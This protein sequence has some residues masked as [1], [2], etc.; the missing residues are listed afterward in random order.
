[1]SKQLFINPQAIGRLFELRKGSS[2]I[3]PGAFVVGTA[4]ASFMRPGRD[5]F[6]SKKAIGKRAGIHPRNVSRYLRELENAGFMITE[7]RAGK[8]SFYN[9]T[10]GNSDAPLNEKETSN[11]SRA[12]HQEHQY[13]PG[14]SDA[15]N[16][17]TNKVTKKDLLS[18]YSPEQQ[19][20][21]DLVFCE[22]KKTRKAGKIK[23][24]VLDRQL[25]K[26]SKYPEG[27]VIEGIKIYIDKGYA[28]TKKD[29]NYLL[30]IIRRCNE[31]NHKPSTQKTGPDIF[32]LVNE[33]KREVQK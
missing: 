11:I 31:E 19:E 10:P 21:I 1:M 3:S 9:L 25:E 24:S 4:L 15:H 13:P 20:I 12:E 7:K 5:C 33:S 8:S 30:G 27:Q 26:W 28:F 2:P 17:E 18:R 14:K 22:L 32:D 29:E 23:E 6:P 16:K